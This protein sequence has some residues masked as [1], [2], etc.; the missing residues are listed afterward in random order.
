M[1]FVELLLNAAMQAQEPVADDLTSLRAAVFRRLQ[2]SGWR[3]SLQPVRGLPHARRSNEAL[4]AAFLG[5]D[6]DA[7]EE[8]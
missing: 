4:F 5:G 2:S 6:A 7:F 1:S 3:S 8:L